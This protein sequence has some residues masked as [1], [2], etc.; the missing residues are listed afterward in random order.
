MYEDLKGANKKK[1]GILLIIVLI[2]CIFLLIINFVNCSINVLETWEEREERIAIERN[3]FFMSLTREQILED[4][5]Y[6]MQILEENYPLFEL[7]YR[8][9]GVDMFENASGLR[10]KLADETVELG[11]DVF[12]Q[13]MR[14]GLFEPVG[15][16]G[17]LQIINRD[18]YLSRLGDALNMPDYPW[19]KFSYNLFTLHPAVNFYG[20]VDEDDIDAAR[21]RYRRQ[22]G[23]VNVV[24]DIIEEGRIGYMRVNRMLGVGSADIVTVRP[25][26][27][28]LAGYEHLIIDIRDNPGGDVHGFLQLVTSAHIENIVTVSS[29]NFIRGGELNIEFMDTV[30]PGRR[31]S[32]EIVNDGQFI[33][34]GGSSTLNFVNTNMNLDEISSFDYAMRHTQTLFPLQLP[35]LQMTDFDGQI[36]L[37]INEGSVSAAE[38][39]ASLYKNQNLAILVGNTTRGVV[40][41]PGLYPVYF[42]LPNS[43]AIVRYDIAYTIDSSG[44]PLEEGIS[45]HI[46]NRPGMDAL[47]TV[48]A[49]IQEGAY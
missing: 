42:M 45:P 41:N 34:G 32:F 31:N 29:F 22:P 5:D 1:I 39:I 14:D 13:M 48:L 26:Y 10:V 18:Y 27:N 40:G 46:F 19:L 37:L 35:N 7:V 25:F 36:W 9:C 38:Q 20:E 17:H 12:L 24:V 33:R 44:R 6:M 28:Q 47:E 49:L 4:F 8:V 21:N 30:H 15:F 3:E 11:L 2:F 23:F 16:R 43:G